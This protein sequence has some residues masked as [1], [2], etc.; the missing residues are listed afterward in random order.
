MTSNWTRS[1][2]CAIQ[3]L[4]IQN[5]SGKAKT[6]QVRQVLKAIDRKEAM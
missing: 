6:Y 5:D 2:H 3:V 4:N 1:A